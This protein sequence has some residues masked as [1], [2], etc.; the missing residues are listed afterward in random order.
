MKA[1]IGWGMWPVQERQEIH[2]DF[3]RVWKVTW[4]DGKTV[5]RHLWKSYKDDRRIK[6]AQNRV[7]WLALMIQ[8]Y[9]HTNHPWWDSYLFE[10][11]ELWQSRKKKKVLYTN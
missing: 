10:T 4:G 7:W 6:Q 5:L 11:M 3:G 8:G 2:T 9:M 1:T